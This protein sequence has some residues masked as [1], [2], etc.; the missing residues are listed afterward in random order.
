M[1]ASS[2]ASSVESDQ[3]MATEVKIVSVDRGGGQLISNKRK[4]DVAVQS[5][6]VVLNPSTIST[7][8]VQSGATRI[9]VAL[10]QVCPATRARNRVANYELGTAV[11]S[12]ARR[13][14]FT[15]SPCT[16]RLRNASLPDAVRDQ[17]P[18]STPEEIAAS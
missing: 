6:P 18:S 13:T 9:V 14:I 7:I 4:I 10:L 2:S 15:R 3:A 8:A 17:S 11:E 5:D 16:R 1:H 12:G